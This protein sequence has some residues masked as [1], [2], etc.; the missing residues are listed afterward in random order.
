MPLVEHIHKQIHLKLVYYGP[1]LGG[2]T[3]NLEHIHQKT[4]PELRGKLI[5]LQNESE[6]TIFFDLLPVELGLFRGYSLRLHLCTVPGQIRYDETRKLILRHADAVAFIVDSQPQAIDANIESALNLDTN[7]RLQG[8]D[9]TRI[10]LVVQ[11]NKRDLPGVLDIAEL[12]EAIGI[13]DGVPEIEASARLGFGVFETLRMLARMC[14][15][16][17]PEPTRM[18]NGRSPSIMPGH[19]TSMYPEGRASG[20]LSSRMTPSPPEPPISVSSIP[21]AP[22][23]PRVPGMGEGRGD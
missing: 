1:G 4:K 9:P 21:R 14:L 15:A 5:S 7:L 19:R 2:K 12:R 13:P 23:M 11:Y 18:P 3:T 20:P 16:L 17:L 22:G 6:R 8:D 10:P